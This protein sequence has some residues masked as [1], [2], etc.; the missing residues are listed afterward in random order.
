LGTATVCARAIIMLAA[1][2]NPTSGIAED[3]G[4]QSDM[5]IDAKMRL[6]VIEIT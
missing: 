4:G 6:E 5:T 1:L 2:F 3:K